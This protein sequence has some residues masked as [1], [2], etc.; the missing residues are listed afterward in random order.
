MRLSGLSVPDAATPDANTRS[1]FV[2]HAPRAFQSGLREP[3]VLPSRR[4]SRSGGSLI[5]GIL[6]VLCSLL[7]ISLYLIHPF[8]RLFERRTAASLLDAIEAKKCQYC[9]H[10]WHPDPS[11]PMQRTCKKM[12]PIQDN[13]RDYRLFSITIK[14]TRQCECDSGFRKRGISWR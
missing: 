7:G 1:Q 5:F 13:E 8:G 10:S 6:A 14:D 2:S 4:R 11:R 12:V 9:N 3:S